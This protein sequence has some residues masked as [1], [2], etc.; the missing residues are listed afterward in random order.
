MKYALLIYEKPG[1][2]DGVGEAERNGMYGEYMALARIRGCVGGAQLQPVATATTV[3]V[4]DG[5]DADDRRPVRGH[6]GGVRR[7]L[8]VRG[9]QPRR[10]ARDGRADPGRALRRLGRGASGRGARSAARAGLPRASGAGSSPPGR[11]PRR[12][13][14]RRG[15]RPGRVRDRGRALAARRH[16]RQPGRAGSSR[17]RATA[18]STACA[19]TARSPR[20]R[21]CSRCPRPRRTTMDDDDDRRRAARADLHLLPP[22]AR[23]RGA[24]GAHPARARRPGDRGDRAR[25]PGV[26][27]DDEAR[28]ST[29]AKAKIKARASRSACR[30]TSCC[31]TGCEA[32]LAVIYLVFNEGYGGRGDLAA[33]AIRLGRVLAELMPDEPEVP[34][35]SR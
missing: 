29:R 14:P 10:G 8:R 25:V 27:G 34:A 7:L 13:R 6:Q 4:Q 5:R 9:R 11:L 17:P 32:V 12:L 16:A 28:G 30:P 23:D 3:R 31:P 21:G 24:G 20:R 19:A 15:G 33:E 22:G 35:C 1:A 18:R 2:L 26:R